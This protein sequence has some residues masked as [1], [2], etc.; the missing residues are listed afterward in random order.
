[1]KKSIITLSCI[2]LILVIILVYGII[3]KIN[4]PDDKDSD[5]ET[6]SKT[7]VLTL[8]DEIKDDTIWSGTFQLIWNDLKNEVTEQDI[9]FKPQLAV[10]ENL[11]KE[12]FTTDDISEQYYYKT[13]KKMTSSLKEQ[14]QEAIKEKF[15]ETSDALD[16][17][18]LE[19]YDDTYFLYAMLKKELK[20][21][22]AFED[23]ENGKFADSDDVE[24]FGIQS[25]DAQKL[26]EQVSVLY[27]NSKDDFA[28]KLYTKQEDGIILCKNP[29]GKTFKEIYEGIQAKQEAYEGSSN[30]EKGE[31]LKIP[32]MFLKEKAEFR[33]LENK[34]FSFSED[35]KYIIEKALQT[36]EFDL[37]GEGEN[38]ESEAEIP[39]IT[40]IEVQN[41][42]RDFSLDNTFSIFLI[43]NGKDKPYFAGKINDVTKFQ[44]IEEE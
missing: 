18:K 39:E 25:E 6:E 16:K 10:V 43:E 13:Y 44:K 24:Y 41:E 26:K 32:K 23:L 3:Q 1:M 33:Q 11:N 42:L 36:I 37:D 9:V 30:L 15:S 31:K 12:M 8:E 28:I 14:L 34:P 20:F 2:M 17:L 29:E 19:N 21:E 4:G 7:T 5:E 40:E 22:T 27:Y 35:E 38:A